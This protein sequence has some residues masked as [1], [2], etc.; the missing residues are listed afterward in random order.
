[1]CIFGDIKM[2]RYL[3]P[4]TNCTF[5]LP[6]GRSFSTHDSVYTAPDD[7]PEVLAYLD[8]MVRV[9]NCRKLEPDAKLELTPLQKLKAISEE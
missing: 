5:T 7:D 1:M 2:S 3:F 6:S 9:G 8:D 4:T